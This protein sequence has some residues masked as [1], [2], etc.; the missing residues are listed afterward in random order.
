MNIY[1][2]NLAYRA[3]EMD[4]R[5]QFEAFGAVSAVKI[6]TDRD[7]GLSKGFCFV[8]MPNDDEAKKAI[9]SLNGN[10]F[11]GRALVVNQARERTER[12]PFQGGGNG[13]G[14]RGPRTGGGNG[15]RGGGRGDFGGQRSNRY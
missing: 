3:K 12:A 6:V 8:E 5:A 14:P 4:I 11:Q 1:V 2:G 15:P 13:G 7:S 10:D 9:D